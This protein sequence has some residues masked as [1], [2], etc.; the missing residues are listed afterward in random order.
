M[1]TFFQF[2]ANLTTFFGLSKKIFKKQ[3]KMPNSN[4]N[5]S[6]NSVREVSLPNH[7]AGTPALKERPCLMDSNL[8]VNDYMFMPA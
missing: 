5:T 2:T 6:N 7:Q 8:T 4:Q 3:P 1:D